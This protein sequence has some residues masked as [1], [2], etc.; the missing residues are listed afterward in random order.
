MQ[1][2]QPPI[3]HNTA[4]GSTPVPNSNKHL[5]R[6]PSDVDLF[7]QMALDKSLISEASGTEMTL[8]VAKHKFLTETDMDGVVES[9]KEGNKSTSA[10][11]SQEEKG[12]RDGANRTSRRG[13]SDQKTDAKR[14]GRS[15]SQRSRRS[16]SPRKRRSSRSS[17]RTPAKKQ[18]SPS[19]S[20]KA[21][22]AAPQGGFDLRNRPA[23]KSYHVVAGLDSKPFTERLSVAFLGVV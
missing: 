4:P 14:S 21:F 18:R 6:A 2:Q 16:P 9:T 1:Q 15:P 7:I 17:S 13:T 23:F 11:T 19:P 22:H 3:P 20:Y 8:E 5:W 10:D 12:K